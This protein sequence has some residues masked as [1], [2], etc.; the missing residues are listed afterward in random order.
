MR[1]AEPG[2]NPFGIF[3]GIT[4]RRLALRQIDDALILAS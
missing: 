1:S 2:G 4:V 3:C